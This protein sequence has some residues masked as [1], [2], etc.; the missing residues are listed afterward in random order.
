MWGV[1]KLL[2]YCS[3]NIVKFRVKYANFYYNPVRHTIIGHPL[4]YMNNNF[5][6]FRFV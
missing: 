2:E 4:L 1:G 3:S 5:G 6:G